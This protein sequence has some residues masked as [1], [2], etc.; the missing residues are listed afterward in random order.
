MVTA[1]SGEGAGF[2]LGPRSS[3]ELTA[4]EKPGLRMLCQECGP[5]GVQEL[6]CIS[7]PGLWCW[8]RGKR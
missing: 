5:W 3:T 7:L 8:L 1:N 2:Y 4:L 6:L